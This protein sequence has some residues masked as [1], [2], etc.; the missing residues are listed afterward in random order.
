MPTGTR[1]T[2]ASPTKPCASGRPR[3]AESY[4]DGERL[5]GAAAHTGADAL[6]PGYGFLSEHA[7]FARACEAAGVTWIG[8]TPDNS[9]R[10]ARKDTA[11]ELAA[12]RRRSAAGRERRRSATRD[13]ALDDRGRHRLSRDVEEPIRGRRHRHAAVRLAAPTSPTRSTA[14]PVWRAVISAT[15][16]ASSNGS[17]SP[18][19][20]SRCRSS[21]TDVGQVVTLG[22]RDCSLQRRNQK[23]IEET[24]APGL[25]DATRAALAALGRRARCRGRIPLGGNGRVRRRRRHRRVRVPRGEHAAPGRASGDRDGHRRRPRRVDGAPRARRSSAARRAGGFGATARSLR[26]KRASTPRIPRTVTDR[27]RDT[28]RSGSRR[29]RARRHL[30]RRSVPRSP[31]TTTRCSPR[32]SCA[33]TP[34]P[35]RSHGLARRTRGDPHRRDRDEP[36]AAPRRGRR[37]ALPRRSRQTALLDG[38][39]VGALDDVVEVSARGRRR[40]CRTGPGASATG[41][42][43]CPRRARWTTSPSGS[44]T[45]SS[46]MRRAQPRSSAR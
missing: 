46:A 42:S 34:A 20:T 30:A 33:A 15:T 39:D 23:V 8:P 45:G 7:G 3:A 37:R 2:S 29:R 26:S 21:A 13:D 27:A 17:S 11:R 25:P 22:E 1:R 28:S 5:L 40:P 38:I 12:G 19:A 36:G 14:S 4:L 6:H 18:R 31:R 43:A 41:R 32:S 10:S 24:P 44:R 16:R 35:T 9:R